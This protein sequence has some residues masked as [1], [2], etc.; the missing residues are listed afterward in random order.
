M[1]DIYARILERLRQG[2]EALLVTTC[3][4]GR[5]TKTL[6]DANTP[7]DGGEPRREGIR[8]A[9]SGDGFILTERFFPKTRL[10]IL[11]AGHIAV[12]LA[13]MGEMLHFETVVFDD[14]PS[15]ANRER[16]P[17]A[18]DVICDYFDNATTRLSIRSG[19]FVAIVT[20]GHK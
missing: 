17:G 20:R 18:G 14:R 8:V 10:V 5:M 12:P 2:K 1:H 7:G 9:E 13:K 11:G 6:R 16:F 19:D 15:F 4:S 3:R